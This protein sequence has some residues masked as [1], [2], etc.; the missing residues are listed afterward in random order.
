[1][2]ADIEELKE[3][4][5]SELH[6]RRLNAKEVLTPQNGVNFYIPDR[7]W[8]S[9][10]I[11]TRSGSENIHFNPGQPRPR[12][13]TRDLLGES[14]GTPPPRQDSSP[15][16]VKKEMISGP[17]QGTTFIVIKWN[18]E[19]NC[20]RREEESFPIPLK[21]IDVT[22][23]TYTSLDV[24]LEKN[25]EDHWNVDGKKELSDAW[26]GITRFI[27]L[28]ERPREGFARSEERTYKETNNLSSKQ[29]MT[30]YVEA[31]VWCSEKESKT[32]MGYR[33]TKARQCQTIKRNILY[34]NKR[35][36]IQ[37]HNESRS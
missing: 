17:F 16:M 10:I 14:D 21:Y 22:R 24:S 33:E 7:R 4:D 8:N 2:V 13:R 3:M 11:W 26:T 12:R 34:W 6:A 9:Q 37:A 31:H 27:L 32:K 19:S 35:R 25:I 30:R 20:T 36:R 29:C 28:N 23:T 1:M 5:A 18:S 15:M